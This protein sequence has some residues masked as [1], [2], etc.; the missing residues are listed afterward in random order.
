MELGMGG[1]GLSPFAAATAVPPREYRQAP[2]KYV[3]FQS[4]KRSL[5][6][7]GELAWQAG[8]SAVLPQHN[9]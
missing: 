1:P 6:W 2:L 3:L 5:L 9:R 7:N 4:I 8:A